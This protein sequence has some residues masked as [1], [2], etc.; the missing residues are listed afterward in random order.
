MSSNLHLFREIRLGKGEFDDSALG[1]ANR[2]RVGDKL[3][4]RGKTEAVS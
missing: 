2:S 3:H 1:P 4:L